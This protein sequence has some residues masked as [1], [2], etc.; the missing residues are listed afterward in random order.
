MQLPRF[1]AQLDAAEHEHR[2]P[3][4]DAPGD[5]REPG[6]E[7]VSRGRDPQAGTHDDF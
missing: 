7:L 4:R 5:D 1:R 3:R 2:R 6:R